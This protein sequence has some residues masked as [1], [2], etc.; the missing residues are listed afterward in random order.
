MYYIVQTASLNANHKTLHRY[1]ITYSTIR[2]VVVKIN[3]YL[4]LLLLQLQK[5]HVCVY[6][7]KWPI[8]YVQLFHRKFLHKGFLN[9]VVLFL[10]DNLSFNA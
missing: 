7:Y 4:K 8:S 10:L 3:K 5:L 9:L 6:S 2:Y 1:V